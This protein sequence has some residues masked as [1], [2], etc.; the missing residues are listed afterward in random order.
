M[1][2]GG[3]LGRMRI[4]VGGKRNGGGRKRSGGKK[5][6]VASMR[7]SCSAAVT[8]SDAVRRLSGKKWRKNGGVTRKVSV[9]MLLSV[10]R[11]MRPTRRKWLNGN[12]R[13]NPRNRRS[14]I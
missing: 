11:R 2:S 7:R 5:R 14:S 9:Q 6:S 1:G 3:G 13:M 12:E 4:V 8:R 10:E